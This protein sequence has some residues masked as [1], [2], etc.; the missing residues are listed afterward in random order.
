MSEAAAPALFVEI[1]MAERWQSI[2]DDCD[3][4][5]HEGSFFVEEGSASLFVDI[6]DVPCSNVSHTDQGENNPADRSAA[7]DAACANDDPQPEQS[8]S[9]RPLPTNVPSAAPWPAALVLGRG[10]RSELLTVG[11]RASTVFHSISSGNGVAA[12]HFT[13]RAS[14]SVRGPPAR[15]GKPCRIAPQK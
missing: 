1:H 8:V 2:I 4:Q 6:H 15:N 13:N 12:R 11:A 5:R 10:E 14:R 9:A 3:P 7:A